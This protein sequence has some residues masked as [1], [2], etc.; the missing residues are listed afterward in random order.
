[1]R[2]KNGFMYLTSEAYINTRK[3]DVFPRIR[4]YFINYSLLWIMN[5]IGFLDNCN[6][7]TLTSPIAPSYPSDVYR[8]SLRLFHSHVNH[9]RMNLSILKT[10]RTPLVQGLLCLPLT[11]RRR[12]LHG[13][14]VHCRHHL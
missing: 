5:P 10:G 13:T 4:P 14:V 8:N 6:P 2:G 1:M 7:S 9:R 11:F 12:F 3:K